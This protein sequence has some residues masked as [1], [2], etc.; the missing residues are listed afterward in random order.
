M[1]KLKGSVMSGSKH[2]M[3]LKLMSKALDDDI[4]SSDMSLED[5][6]QKFSNLMSNEFKGEMDPHMLSL[7]LQIQPN[8]IEDLI[9]LAHLQTSEPELFSKLAN[10]NKIKTI[11]AVTRMDKNDRNLILENIDEINASEKTFTKISEILSRDSMT[12]GELYLKCSGYWSSVSRYLEA[13]NYADSRDR[14]TKGE[15]S[16]SYRSLLKTMDRYLKNDAKVPRNTDDKAPSLKQLN[17]L[18]RGIVQD[19]ERK[20]KLFDNET[21]YSKHPDSVEYMRKYM[22]HYDFEN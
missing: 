3:G 16:E 12:L 10:I 21:L 6:V 13:I 17:W 4:L 19:A 5:R 1:C 15:I 22:A 11:F 14:A 7:V 8:Y 20:T 18:E 9:Y 2:N